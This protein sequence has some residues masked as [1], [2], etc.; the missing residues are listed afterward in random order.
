MTAGLLTD[1]HTSEKKTKLSLISII[2][3][4]R[5]LTDAWELL[6]TPAYPDASCK[7]GLSPRKD[8]SQVPKLG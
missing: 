2:E 5:E 4:V 8:P 6:R 3:K 1:L 7:T